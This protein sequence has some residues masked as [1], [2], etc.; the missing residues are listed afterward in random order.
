MEVR[1]GDGDRRGG[2][3]RSLDLVSRS[4]WRPT[5]ACHRSDQIQPPAFIRCL[6][7]QR[8]HKLSATSLI[9]SRRNGP[10]LKTNDRRTTIE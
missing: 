7:N 6:H 9:M 4:C 1:F 5:G 10:K 2:F 8:S 3:E